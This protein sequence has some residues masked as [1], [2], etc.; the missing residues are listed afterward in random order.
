VLT[1]NPAEARNIARAQQPGLDALDVH[2]LPDKHQGHNTIGPQRRRPSDVQD[3]G[4]VSLP[5]P[6]H[7]LAPVPWSWKLV[8]G[9]VTR[10]RLPR[11][12][13]VQPSWS[14]PVAEPG[15][16]PVGATYLNRSPPVALL[17]PS[18]KQ[19][20]MTCYLPTAPQVGVRRPTAAAEPRC[21][22]FCRLVPLPH[23][24]PESAC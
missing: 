22:H 10:S 2:H 21:A 1:R 3:V 8:T 6:A 5:Q 14:P 18:R 4:L 13:N 7:L 9:A 17:T 11:D 15:G 12:P 20:P 23:T 24:V 19:T 16:S